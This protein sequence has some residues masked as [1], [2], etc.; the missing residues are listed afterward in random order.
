MTKPKK[1]SVIIPRKKPGPE[2][3]YD[4]RFHPG[5]AKTL[6]SRGA[7]VAEFADACGV[8]DR[9]IR[10]W[11]ANH[12]EFSQA[13]KFAAAAYDERVERAL[14]ERAIGYEVDS[15]E[16][17][18]VDGKVLHIP[19]RRQFPPDV[20]AA[21]LYLTNRMPHK[22]KRMVEV[23][24]TGEKIEDP[25]IIVEEIQAKILRLA[26]KYQVALPGLTLKGKQ[27][28]SGSEQGRRVRELYE[29][30]MRHPDQEGSGCWQNPIL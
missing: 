12:P 7:T 26:A 14:V 5:Y 1:Q 15:E 18:V 25:E 10:R 3:V 20:G 9:T 19:V 22:Y 8:T 13:F 29:Q 23:Q 11:F 21:T 24:N 27:D 30:G 17:K 6:A 4:P 16:I 2:P 28:G